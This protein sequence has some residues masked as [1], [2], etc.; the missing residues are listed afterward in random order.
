M[1]EQYALNSYNIF[2]TEISP[3]VDKI[4]KYSDGDKEY[5]YA[6]LKDMSQVAQ[7]QSNQLSIQEGSIN[8]NQVEGIEGKYQQDSSQ[9]EYQIKNQDLYNYI[10]SDLLP[11]NQQDITSKA[12]ERLTQLN[13]DE[14]KRLSDEAHQ[15]LF[16]MLTQNYLGVFILAGLFKLITVFFLF[17]AP[18]FLDSLQ[19]SLK[20]Y[21]SNQN[22]SQAD[23]Q[24]QFLRR[25]IYINGALLALSF[26]LF[27]I[28]DSQYSYQIKKLS[29]QL[30]Q[31]LQANIYAHALLKKAYTKYQSYSEDKDNQESQIHANLNNLITI[32]VDTIINFLIS[33]HETWSL[34]LK[35]IIGLTLLYLKMESAVIVG[36]V[37]TFILMMINFY[38]AKRIGSIF[39]QILKYKDQRVGLTRD[40]LNGIRQIQLLNWQNIFFQKILDLRNHE[41]RQ[42]SYEKYLDAFCVFFWAS[43]SLAISAVTFIL[44]YNK[45]KTFENIN[46]FTAIYL[47]EMLIGP[48]NAL[49]WTISGLIMSKTSFSRFND[50]LQLPNQYKYQNKYSSQLAI[51]VKNISSKWPQIKEETGD[52]KEE[53]N[54]K[55]EKKDK[56][57]PIQQNK[58]GNIKNQVIPGSSKNVSAP[59]TNKS[60]QSFKQSFSESIKQLNENEQRMIKKNRISALSDKDQDITPKSIVNK[61]PLSTQKN[62]F[63]N[64]QVESNKNLYEDDNLDSEFNLKINNLQIPKG[65]FIIVNGN[66]ASGK[67]ALLKTFLSEMNVTELD[68]S[69]NSSLKVQGS[70]AYVS[71]NQWLYDSSLRSNILFHAPFDRKYYRACIFASCLHDDISKF[72]DFDLYE[73]GINGSKLS[74]GQQ[75]R[76]CIARALYSK[77]DIYL[78]DNIFSSV[79]IDVA[80]HIFKFG[81]RSLL[82]DK[83][84]ILS[85]NTI[86]YNQYADYIINITDQNEVFIME[87]QQKIDLQFNEHVDLNIVKI[88]DSTV[89]RKNIINQIQSNNNVL[90]LQNQPNNQ[91]DQQKAEEDEIHLRLEPRE[92]GLIDNKVIWLYVKNIGWFFIFM[93][94]LSLILMQFSQNYYYVWLKDYVNGSQVFMLGDTENKFI[95]TLIALS[96]FNLFV[97]LFRAFSF[98]YGNLISSQ[99]IFLLLTSTVLFQKASFFMKHS[100]GAI[101]SRFAGDTAAVDY[102]I[103]F[104]LNILLKIFFTILGSFL[105]IASQMPLTLV[106]IAI[107][108][109]FYYFIQAKY[110]QSSREIKRLDSANTSAMLT[111]INESA[112]GIQIIR[113]FDLEAIF[114]KRFFIHMKNCSTTNVLLSVLGI[115]FSIRL[116]ILSLLLTFSLLVYTCASVFFYDFFQKYAFLLQVDANT[117][118]LCLVY[119]IEITNLL[120]NLILTL[121]ETEKEFICLERIN[122]YIDEG[123]EDSK[124]TKEQ[125]SKSLL[126]NSLLRRKIMNDFAVEFHEVYMAYDQQSDKDKNQQDQQQS[127]F[128]LKGLSL[129]IEKGKKYGIIGKTGSGKSSILNCLLKIYDYQDGEI[130]VNGENIKFMKDEYLSSLISIIPQHGFLYSG[131]VKENVDPLDKYSDMQIFKI[132][133]QLDLQKSKLANLNFKIEEGGKNISEGEK[134]QISLIRAILQNKQIICFDE[135][136]SNLDEQNEI[137]IEKYLDGLKNKTVI[138]ITHNPRILS[139]F[140]AIYIIEEGQAIKTSFQ[141]LLLDIQNNHNDFEQ[142]DQNF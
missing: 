49:P 117:L 134:Q 51:Q 131:T 19:S 108:L 15:S 46:V 118:G 64:Q 109:I 33:F 5:S 63:K 124:R 133:Q 3:L 39:E 25:Q 125:E 26:L 84:V 66:T 40:I 17:A 122:Q 113:A 83:T 68:E 132:F 54:D 114:N 140:D 23:S 90:E 88:S 44:Y 102:S 115:W 20:E 78:L 141:D 60:K 59:Q 123:D 13:D 104:N 142:V 37:V 92:K 101:I 47:F 106:I 110:R 57:L 107:I 94:M 89:I 34:I 127:P 112:F 71:Q 93:I 56:V 86:R 99:S 119:S 41:F 42:I 62:I 21:K 12:F 96:V 135:A 10:V 116:Q 53:S 98:A 1:S 105:V 11:E 77:K 111:H 31:Y 129:Q 76:V 128:V 120:R 103:S 79:D 52:L 6:Q 73:V 48:L 7:N 29:T 27:T 97:T 50:F 32:D 55:E 87:N 58:Q 81:L 35:L 18:W 43:S 24:S 2:F 91:N 74:G 65:A 22:T 69:L 61:T 70:L 126:Q 4:Q 14:S 130:Y 95:I 67:T 136:T 137:M 30:K 36:F 121:T 45:N 138:L 38:I 16:R 9:Q 85:S 8:K 28:C 75:Q 80:D 100:I 139:K 72:E 82:R